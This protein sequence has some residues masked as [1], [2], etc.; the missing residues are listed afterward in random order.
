MQGAAIKAM[1]EMHQIIHEGLDDVLEHILKSEPGHEPRINTTL[2]HKT[3]GT[4]GKPAAMYFQKELQ[5]GCFYAMRSGLGIQIWLRMFV[6][7]LC[8]QCGLRHTH[9]PFFRH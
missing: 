1:H 2:H 5:V 8:E 4:E 6:C 9:L 3:N 7:L